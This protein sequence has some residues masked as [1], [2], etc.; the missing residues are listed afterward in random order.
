MALEQFEKEV[1]DIK[2]KIWNG[3]YYLFLS[4]VTCKE[5]KIINLF[6]PLVE[7]IFF[8]TSS[9]LNVST[10]RPQSSIIFNPCTD[11]VSVKL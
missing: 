8:G 11:L 2:G 6:G 7:R 10:S 4:L 9:S 3:A 1:C 5:L